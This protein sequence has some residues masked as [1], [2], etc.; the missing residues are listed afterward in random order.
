MEAVWRLCRNRGPDGHRPHPNQNMVYLYLF[1]YDGIAAD[2]L[3]H[4]GFLDEHQAVY[5]G[6]QE[7]S[8]MVSLG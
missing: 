6:G 2:R 4:P 1:S 3:F 7:K 8:V 5:T